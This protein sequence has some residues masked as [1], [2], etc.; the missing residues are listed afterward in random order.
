MRSPL[1]A[2][3]LAALAAD[4]ASSLQAAPHLD[5]C[6]FARSRCP[7]VVA[8][9]GSKRKPKASKPV[10]AQARL[11]RLQQITRELHRAV[12]GEEFEAAAKLRDEV[13]SLQMDTEVAVLSANTAFYHA[14]NRRDKELMG[15][16]WS[17]TNPCVVHPGTAPI[18]GR[19]E[20]LSSWHDIF[21]VEPNGLRVEPREVRVHMLG[22]GSAC[23]T[24]VERFSSGQLPPSQLSSINV[25]AAGGDGRWQLVSHH[26]G[27]LMVRRPNA[28]PAAGADGAPFDEV[29]LDDLFDEEES[30]DE[31]GGFEE[32]GERGPA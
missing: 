5:A 15:A 2:A 6:Q 1:R 23:V 4:A 10:P 31:E 3:I 20:V 17:E 21:D 27:P 24:C 25:F 30:D 29:T 9:Q 7:A 32:G 22:A 13:A 26:S 12:A 28:A 8:S 14:F 16:L 18:Y 11:E 19:D